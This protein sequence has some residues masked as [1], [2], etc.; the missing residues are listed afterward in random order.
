LIAST[1]GTTHASSLSGNACVDD[2]IAQYLADGT[3]PDRKDG[4][5]ADAFCDPLPLPKPTAE[6]DTAGVVASAEQR[7]LR[8]ELGP[9]LMRRSPN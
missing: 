1:G 4:D 5:Q 9:V 7:A 6:A 8:R 2:Q 3:L